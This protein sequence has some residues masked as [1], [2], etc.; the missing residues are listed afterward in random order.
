MDLRRTFDHQAFLYDKARPH[1]PLD[2]FDMIIEVTGIK[3]GDHLL[4]IGPGTGQATQPFAARGFRITGVELGEH[5]AVVARHRLRHY[6]DIDIIT[7]AFE[8][9]ELPL[10]EFELAYSATAFHWIKP[11]VKFAKTHEL[12]VPGGYLAIIHTNHTSDEEGD[13]YHVASQPIY[14]H[15]WPPRTDPSI[16]PKTH[17]IKPPEFDE[18]LFKPVHFQVFPMVIHYTTDEYIELLGTYSPT[19]ALKEEQ[20]KA[21]LDEIKQLVN[22][23]FGGTRTK[24]LAMS[25]AI[26]RAI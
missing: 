3:A 19:L 25:L 10:H 12:L 26:G 7:G 17:E 1:Y 14:D 18:K 23:Q 21:F 9:A 5:L 13:A 20:R 16:L 24:H 11:E 6:P 15:Y 22:D 4:E 2:L 8:T